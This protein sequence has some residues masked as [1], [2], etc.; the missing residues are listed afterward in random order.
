MLFDV[1]L[2]GIESDLR[3]GFNTA[4]AH[5][6]STARAQLEAALAEVAKE[7]AKGLA[8]VARER[9]ELHRE[10]EAM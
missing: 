7:R 2:R 1:L 5:L 9:A 6:L 10:I 8:E 4:L 3:A